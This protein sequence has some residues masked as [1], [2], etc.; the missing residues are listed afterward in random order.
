MSQSVREIF[1]RLVTSGMI[2]I[3]PAAA[4]VFCCEGCTSEP[5]EDAGP[6]FG[7]HSNTTFSGYTRAGV[8]FRGH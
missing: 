5:Q 8:I 3:A 7:H 1:A 2:A 6:L 4:F